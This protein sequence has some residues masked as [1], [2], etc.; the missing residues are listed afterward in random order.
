LE[1]LYLFLLVLLTGT[2]YAALG[3]TAILL[4]SVIVLFVLYLKNPKATYNV[5]LLGSYIVLSCL[6]VFILL[7]HFLIVPVVNNPLPY[8]G[9][10]IRFT[11]VGLFYV[12]I[13]SK[14]INLSILLQGVLKLIA[15]HAFISFILSFF[16]GGFL[17]SV[18]TEG[19]NTNT[20][21]YLFFYNSSFQLLGLNLY[22]NQGLFWE[23]GILQLYMN[24]LFFISSFIIPNKKLQF[25]TAFLIFTTYSTTGI[26][27]L[28][29]Q[30][31]VVL[32]SA[33]AS[34]IQKILITLGLAVIM[35][36]LFVLN[37]TQKLN[38]DDGDSDI[39]S[40]SLRIY[41]L[42]EG[43]QITRQYPLTGIG[44][45]Q[46]AYVAFKKANSSLTNNYSQEFSDK[47]SER[48]SSNSILFFLTR[49][50]I[51]VSLFWFFMLYK[52][53]FIWQKSGLF[54][55]IVMVEN[56]SEPLLIEPF[57]LLFAAS[58]LYGLITFRFN[59]STQLILPENVSK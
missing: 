41:D 36:P 21:G 44:L 46:E 37:Y 47:V 33:K 11:S 52:Q 38:N 13:K 19:F 57:F 58:G 59:N 49:F 27:I 23:P 25:L 51:P 39:T 29:L 7:F 9:L 35:L 17:I 32:F 15:L 48:R 40:S 56:F 4:A 55:I 20:F 14:Q 42:L 6:M 12:Y 26:G 5:N 18:Q 54:F 24:I 53:D 3:N 34:I 10:S 22:R 50:G 45:S 30:L 8:I 16:V 43:V 1:K 28:L 2:V 31:F